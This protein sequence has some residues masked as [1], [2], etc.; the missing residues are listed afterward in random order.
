MV[1][2]PKGWWVYFLFNLQF[3][4]CCCCSVFLFVFQ[5]WTETGEKG[6]TQIPNVVGKQINFYKKNR[7][8]FSKKK[9]SISLML[10]KCVHECVCER[11]SGRERERE[12]E[13]EGGKKLDY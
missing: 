1:G 9:F 12:R 10:R 5:D 11:E 13:R 6:E 3:F 8:N 7:N 4:C 2:D